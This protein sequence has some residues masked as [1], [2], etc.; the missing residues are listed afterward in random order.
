MDTSALGG[1]LIAAGALLLLATLLFPPAAAEWAG[2]PDRDRQVRN[3]NIATLLSGVVTLIGAAIALAGT[4]WIWPLVGASVAVAAYYL[5]LVYGTHRDRRDAL[6]AVLHDRRVDHT[7]DGRPGRVL[8]ST[9]A[10]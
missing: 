2:G 5:A 6:A 10:R 9:A 4:A 1:G 8:M 3:R 7:E